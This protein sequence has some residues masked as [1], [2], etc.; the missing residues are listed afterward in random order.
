MA[1]LFVPSVKCP[2]C[3]HAND[4]DFRY[5]QCCGYI[6]KVLHVDRVKAIN[7]DFDQID[8]RLQQLL[9]FDQATSYA[10]QKLSLQ[11][12]LEAFLAA[13]PGRVT[14]ATVTPRDICRFLIFKDINGKTQVTHQ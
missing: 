4:I 12:E 10:K 7:V 3:S 5:C 2:S 11:K 13:L 14:L 9:S 8:Q 1:K 6:R